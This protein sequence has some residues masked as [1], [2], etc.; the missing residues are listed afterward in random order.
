MWIVDDGDRSAY[1]TLLANVPDWGHTVSV[2]TMHTSVI[3]AHWKH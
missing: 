2:L 1:A 3:S